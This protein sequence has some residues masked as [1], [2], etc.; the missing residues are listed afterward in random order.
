MR[1]KST[2]SNCRDLLG[3]QSSSSRGFTKPAIEG[4]LVKRGQSDDTV[5][6]FC[7]SRFLGRTFLTPAL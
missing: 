5:E 3:T 4:F 6:T 2:E 1:G 7:V